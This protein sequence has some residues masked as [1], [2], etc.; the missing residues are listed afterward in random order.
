VQGAQDAFRALAEAARLGAASVV[1]TLGGDGCVALTGDSFL[2]L[3]AYDVTVVDTT[4][5][6]DAFVGAFAVA[7]S[8]GSDFADALMFAAAAG[9]ATC[10]H[11]GAQSPTTSDE[12][13]SLLR[14]QPRL[15]R[16]SPASAFLL[17]TPS[18]EG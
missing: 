10:G 9:A 15:P 18:T 16:R 14:Q 2:E 4:G 5:A 12:A 6:G 17:T 7:L 8:H 1:I 3:E 11:S 13:R